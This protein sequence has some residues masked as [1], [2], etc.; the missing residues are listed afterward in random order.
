MDGGCDTSC[1]I[2]RDMEPLE[3]L[4]ELRAKCVE[5]GELLPEHMVAME[6]LKKEDNMMEAPKA[7][8]GKWAEGLAVKDL[9]LEKAEVLFHAG[10]RY[11]YDDEL[12]STARSGVE[13]LQKAGIDVGIMG[14]DETC[15]G[16]RAYS[17]GYQGELTK[18]AEH[19]IENWKQAGVKT[20]VTPCSDCYHCF[21][22]LYDKIR[23]KPEIEI[24]HITEYLSGLLENGSLKPSKNVP[25][26]VTYHDPCHLGRLA[27]PWIQWDGVEK[28]V[29]GQLIVHDPPKEFRKGANGIYDE[30]RDIIRSIPGIHFL[31]MFRIR[32]FAWCCGAQGGVR[33]A[34][35]DM[36]MGTANERI[37]EARTT[38]AE[39]IVTACPWCKRNFLD[40]MEEN[41]TKIKIIDILE[42]LDQSI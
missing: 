27:E 3:A 15:C 28:K 1:K 9:S 21:K 4:Y 35:P 25:M 13:L 39:A 22:V 8:R 20:V 24:L 32:E 14:R 30:P 11:S 18:Y 38:G 37:K 42:L 6:G 36:A 19:N 16:G 17:W 10:C 33:E 7:D 26:K 29:M 34:F 5:D 12:W 40:A 2:N 41:G 31:E 23:L